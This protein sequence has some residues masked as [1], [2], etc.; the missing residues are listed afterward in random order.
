M[1]KIIAIIFVL[2]TLQL[3]AQDHAPS[4]DKINTIEE[5]KQYASQNR[6]V[7]FNIVNR[8][9]DV[10]LFEKIDTTDLKKNI[11]ETFTQYGR[12]TKFI[13][14]TIIRVA[15]I[16][17]IYFDLTKTSRELAEILLSQIQKRLD[18]GETYWELKKKYSHTS[19]I[20]T[21]GPIST[22]DVKKKFKLNIESSE[23]NRNY[24]I[25]GVSNVIGVVIVVE[26]PHDVQAFYSITY[27][28]SR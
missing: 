15:N 11:G 22:G 28:I 14:D 1:K 13:Q 16:K 3:H 5:A 23:V 12:S 7:I 20:F 9:N 6:G 10:F 2:I 4:V 17:S 19:A 24:L 21:S 27:T 26:A 8:E 25:D 18:K